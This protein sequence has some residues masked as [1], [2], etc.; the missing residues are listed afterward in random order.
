MA[1]LVGSS[2]PGIKSTGRAAASSLRYM[3]MSLIGCKA[4]FCCRPYAFVLARAS[5]EPMLPPATTSRTI[6]AASAWSSGDPIMPVSMSIANCSFISFW[7]P[8]L[9]LR[10]HTRATYLSSCRTGRGTCGG[11]PG[12]KISCT[13][14]ASLS[15]GSFSPRTAMTKPVTNWSTGS[16]LAK[17]VSAMRPPSSSKATVSLSCTKLSAASALCSPRSFV[18]SSRMVGRSFI[19]LATV[20]NTQQGPLVRPPTSRMLIN[21]MPGQWRA[22]VS[23]MHGSISFNRAK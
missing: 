13:T 22:M 2:A 6:F 14:K 9:S 8:V 3:S 19:S 12:Y 1:T 5:E 21:S 18:Y 17:P 15:S 23:F 7:L 11:M 4:I 10:P 16:T 20:P